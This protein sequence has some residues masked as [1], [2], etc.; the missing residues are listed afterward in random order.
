MAQRATNNCK[1]TTQSGTICK[2]L[3]K[4]NERFCWQHIHCKQP[5]SNITIKIYNTPRKKQILLSK[6]QD[7]LYKNLEDCFDIDIPDFLTTIDDIVLLFLDDEI[8]GLTTLKKIRK[9]HYLSA[10]CI[11]QSHRGKG[12]CSG[13]ISAIVS[14]KTYRN[15]IIYLEV[16]RNNEKAIHCYEKAGFIEKKRY[17]DNYVEYEYKQHTTYT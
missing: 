7:L 3:V 6:Y 2:R 4:N 11:F 8:I 10:V 15:Q 17:K 14:N 9:R 16:D 1:C 5:I 13:F 12:Y